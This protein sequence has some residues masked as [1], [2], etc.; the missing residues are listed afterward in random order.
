MQATANFK[1]SLLG[2]LQVVA[3]PIFRIWLLRL[4]RLRCETTVPLANR[5]YSQQRPYCVR[6]KKTRYSQAL[7]AKGGKSL[8]KSL[9]THFPQLV[10]YLKI[11]FGPCLSHPGMAIAQPLIGLYGGTTTTME[12]TSER[13]PRTMR[14]NRASDTR[15]KSWQD[16]AGGCRTKREL[17]KFVWTSSDTLAHPILQS[18]NQIDRIFTHFQKFQCLKSSQKPLQS[19][20]HQSKWGSQYTVC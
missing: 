6:I 7:A 9:T 18:A 17:N 19:D 8:A 12:A 4:S 13:V 20:D 14:I 15:R 10:W 3:G 1:E 2:W 16:F 11:S 5:F